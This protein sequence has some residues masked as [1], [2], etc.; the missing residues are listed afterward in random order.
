MS[1]ELSSRFVRTLRLLFDAIDV[2]LGLELL[3]LL[4]FR[5]DNIKTIDELTDAVLNELSVLLG[6]EKTID[7][8]KAAQ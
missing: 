1:D 8:K 7:K 4:I 5:N 2:E 6:Y 3:D